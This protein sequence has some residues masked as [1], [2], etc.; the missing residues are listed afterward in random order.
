MSDVCQLRQRARVRALTSF[1]C[2]VS[3]PS[4]KKGYRGTGRAVWVPGALLAPGTSPRVSLG[5]VEMSVWRGAA[6][7]VA[8]GWLPGTWA[9]KEQ[10]GS[11]QGGC[12]PL[13]AF[14]CQAWS[15]HRWPFLLTGRHVWALHVKGHAH[16]VTKEA[17]GLNKWKGHVSKWRSLQWSLTPRRGWWIETS[18]V[19]HGGFFTGRWADAAPSKLR[20]PKRSLELSDRTDCALDTHTSLMMG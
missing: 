4:A 15:R 20:L 8:E 19:P 14:K 11:G 2:A 17:I 10:S 6:P 1:L 3:R 5:P 16:S 18:P 12:P 13:F 9:R 7:R